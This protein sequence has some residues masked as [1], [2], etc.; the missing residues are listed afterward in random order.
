MQTVT[1]G[2]IAKDAS[3]ARFELRGMGGTL[4]ATATTV[5]TAVSSC[6]VVITDGELTGIGQCGM[7]C[8]VM[9]NS[10][11]MNAGTII[12]SIRCTEIPGPGMDRFWTVR[13]A[14]GVPSMAADFS[15]SKCEAAP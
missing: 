1:V 10:V 2:F 3:G 12:G 5:G 9:I 15:V 8:T 7:G 4:A 13:N 14:E 11:D 6:E